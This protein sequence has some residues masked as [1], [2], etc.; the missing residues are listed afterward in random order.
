MRLDISGFFVKGLCFIWL[1]D[2]PRLAAQQ[3]AKDAH[4]GSVP[5]GHGRSDPPLVS[6]GDLVHGIAA[7][8]D[9]VRKY[10]RA[11]VEREAWPNI[12]YWAS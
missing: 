10:E 6:I 4:L 12:L 2:D 3:D 8:E 1:G 11:V 9:K 5:S 7:R